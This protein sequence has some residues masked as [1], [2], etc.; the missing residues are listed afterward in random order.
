MCEKYHLT[1]HAIDQMTFAEIACLCSD[2]QANLPGE[3]NVMAYAAWWRSLTP[4]ERL[5]VAAEW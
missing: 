3:T 5:D 4:L 2:P 1:P